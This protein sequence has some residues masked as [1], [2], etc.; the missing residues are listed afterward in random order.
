MGALVLTKSKLHEDM[1]QEGG[2]GQKHAAKEVRK[3]IKR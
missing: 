1:D 2:A 3:K